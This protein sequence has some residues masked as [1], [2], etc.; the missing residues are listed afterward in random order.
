MRFCELDD[1][2]EVGL[3]PMDV[4]ACYCRVVLSSMGS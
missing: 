3:E 1:V 4:D 2:W